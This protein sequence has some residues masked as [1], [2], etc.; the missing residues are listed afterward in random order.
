MKTCKKL[1]AI[2]L[3]AAVLLTTLVSG[4]VV[5]AADAN[6]LVIGTTEI[7]KGTATADV[8]FTLTYA[9]ATKAPHSLCTIT[10]DEG[11]TLTALTLGAVDYVKVG[12]TVVDDELVADAAK[13][14]I[15]DNGKN[16]AAGKVLFESAVD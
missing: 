12:D 1:L 9:E 13:I 4:L 16:I 6:T 14:T 8:E 15:D 5:S 11:L 2:A 3:V 10:A 7:V